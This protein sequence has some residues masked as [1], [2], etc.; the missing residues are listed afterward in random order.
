MLDMFENVWQNRDEIS[1]DHC[2]DIT[3]PVS[4]EMSSYLS[5]ASNHWQ[6]AL[7]VISVAGTQFPFPIQSPC[8]STLIR[9]AHTR[10]RPSNIMERRLKLASTRGTPN[11]VK[12]IPPSGDYEYLCEEGRTFLGDGFYGAVEED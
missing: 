5:H 1:V 8:L 2:V 6:I 12:G 11:V 9:P 7:F 4:K 3:L 10:I